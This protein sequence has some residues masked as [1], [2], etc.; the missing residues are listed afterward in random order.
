MATL[1]DMYTISTGVNPTSPS[2]LYKKVVGG[3]VTV[4]REIYEEDPSTTEHDT[5]VFWAKNAMSN[6][7]SIA[8]NMIWRVVADHSSLS[9]AQINLLDDAAVLVSI[10]NAITTWVNTL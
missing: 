10:R 6:P 9:A 5:R 2:T 3:V 7:T 4:A 1:E 8:D